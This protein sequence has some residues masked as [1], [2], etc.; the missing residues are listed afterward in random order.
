MEYNEEE[1]NNLKYELAL[2]YDK[3]NYCQYYISLLRTKHDILFT[4]FNNT[5]YNSKIIKID[6]FLFNFILNYAVN[7]LFF[8]DD[9][10]HQIYEDKG[11]FNLIYQLPQ[12]AYSMLISTVFNILIKIL[13]LS[14]GLIITFKKKKEK[15]NL[16]KRM[17]MLNSKLKTKF[18]I[19]F[20]VSSIF[21]LFF[22]Y[23]ISMFC[24]IYVNT[25]IHLIKDTLLSFALSFVYPFGINLIPGICRIP[26]L[27][28]SKNKRSYLYSFSKL[29]QLI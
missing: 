8:S 1:L 3:R 13:A 5:D 26:A 19:Y 4:F 22:W 7:T 18:I 17:N 6:L 11:S 20:I 28:N 12:I 25:Q 24:S 9:T 16:D 10:M 21:L 15:R 2:K 23:Y 27:S 29:I 14:E